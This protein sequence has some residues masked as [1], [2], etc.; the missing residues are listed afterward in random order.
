MVVVVVVVVVVLGVDVVVVVN[1]RGL[2]GLSSLPLVGQYGIWCR[3]VGS[4]CGR[5]RSGRSGFE[6]G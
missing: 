2:S 6:S 5:R 3:R 4:S 1:S